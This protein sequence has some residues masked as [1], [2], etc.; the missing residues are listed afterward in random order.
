MIKEARVTYSPLGKGL[1][2]QTT[3]IKDQRREQVEALQIL[4]PE[5]E[6]LTIS[7]VIPKDNPNEAVKNEI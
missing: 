5:V 4:K 7:D 2:K 1:E 3:T 6:Q